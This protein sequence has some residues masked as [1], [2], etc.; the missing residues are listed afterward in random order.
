MCVSVCVCLSECTK[1]A[2][3]RSLA[4][5]TAAQAGADEGIA[6]NSA[7]R[8]I[9]GHHFV[10]RGNRGSLA[11]FFTE[12]IRASW[13]LKKSRDFWG[14]VK[15]AAATAENH[16]ILVHSGVCVLRPVC[17]APFVA[18][19]INGEELSLRA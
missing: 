6:E 4:I 8:T 17:Y 9:K 19:Q 7:A 15:I 10:R 3:R 14:A 13:G 18:W 1:I 2:H 11:I 5:F 16:A 12:E